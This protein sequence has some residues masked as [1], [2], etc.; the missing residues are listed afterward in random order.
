M[1][2]DIRVIII[3]ADG[4]AHGLAGFVRFIDN[5]YPLYLSGVSIIPVTPGY[6]AGDGWP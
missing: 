6:F 3:Q 4:T 5:V 1:Q 2:Y